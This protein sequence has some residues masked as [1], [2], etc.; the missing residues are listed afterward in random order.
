MEARNDVDV[1]V[2]RF[3]FWRI[4]KCGFEKVNHI[5]A[6]NGVK[7]VLPVPILLERLVQSLNVR[8]KRS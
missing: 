3:W 6:S 1:E 5:D 2:V 4:S 7:G 8:T